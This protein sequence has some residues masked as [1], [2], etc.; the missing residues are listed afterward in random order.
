MKYD[1]H[2]EQG[3]SR[4]EKFIE[5]NDENKEEVNTYLSMLKVELWQKNESHY[6]GIGELRS[7]E[8]CYEQCCWIQFRQIPVSYHIVNERYDKFNENW[9]HE[10]LSLLWDYQEKGGSEC[11][12]EKRVS[13]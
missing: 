3:W 9:C 4:K 1:P 11:E 6:D 5:I 12:N 8:K 2:Q 10:V 7:Y 13:E